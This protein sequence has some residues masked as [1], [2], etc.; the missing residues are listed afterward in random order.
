M[1]K[2]F[3]TL[4]R[5]FNSKCTQRFSVCCSKFTWENFAKRQWAI[6]IFHLQQFTI[7]PNLQR[8]VK[9]MCRWPTRCTVLINKF[10]SIVCSCSTCFELFTRSKHVEQGKNGGI[11]II[12][13]NCAA[14]WSSTRCN[15]MHGTYK[16][17]S[18][19]NLCAS[20]KAFEDF[21]EVWYLGSAV[22][23]SGNS[24][25]ETYYTIITHSSHIAPYAHFTPVS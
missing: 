8:V 23:L 2:N 10:Y 24:D 11:R 9:E 21:T 15:M 17:R 22:Q 19:K 12:Y 3:V 25:F 18:W 13:K 4:Q 16:V 7:K 20:L 5:C 14:R 6:P 1:L